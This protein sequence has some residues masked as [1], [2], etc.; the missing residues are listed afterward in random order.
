[1]KELFPIFTNSPS[2]VYLDSAATTQKPKV[3]I[4]AMD[5]FL[6]AEYGT[7]HRAVYSLAAQA[8]ERYNRVREAVQAFLHAKS[9]SEIIFTKGTTEGINLVA[10]SFGEAFIQEGDEI[11]IVETEHHANIVPWQMLCSRKKAFLRVL[12]VDDRGDISLEQLQARLSSKVKLLAVSYVSNATG[13]VHPI[14]QIISL[15][16]AFGTKVLVDA[17]QAVS[18]Y[19]IDVQSLDVDFLVFSGHK[20]YGPTGIGVLYGKE[21]LL[22][23]MPPYQGGGDMIQ[24]VAFDQTTYQ[25]PPLK[26]EAGTPAIVE[27]IGLGAAIAFIQGIGFSQ[28]Q[29]ME[30]ALL[31]YALIKLK[32]IPEVVF[33]SE[34]KQRASLLSFVCKGCHPLDIG[35]MLSL[36]NIAVRTGHLCAQPALRRFGHTFVV[37][38]SFAIYNTQEE[39]DFLVQSLQEIVLLLKQ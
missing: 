16:H 18:H 30:R 32:E 7:V 10:F 5:Q 28:I 25:K 34:P 31:D 11:L 22:N 36:R 23:A 2:L 4:D 35:S 29:S 15:A 8:T 20:I 21:A 1:M 3:V 38:V 9:S 37:R 39:I 27:V 19:P 12:P 6:S 14:E 24:T 26:F 17:A 13:A 33:L